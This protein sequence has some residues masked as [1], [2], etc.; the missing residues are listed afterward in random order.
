MIE[1][2]QSLLNKKFN[3]QKKRQAS[4]IKHSEQVLKLARGDAPVR[5]K[6]KKLY[7]NLSLDD[8][9]YAEKKL[10]RT[11]EVAE[12]HCFR[13]NIL[14]TSRS[15]YTWKTSQGEKTICNGCNGNLTALV[16]QAE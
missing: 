8:E 2:A 1:D 15:Q 13:C 10:V 3:V 16:K 7:R 6:K 12:F 11:E 4:G 14:K 5:E 9:A